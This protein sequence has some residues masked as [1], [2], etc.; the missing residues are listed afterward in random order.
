MLTDDEECRCNSSL[1]ATVTRATVYC[2]RTRAQAAAV[3]YSL[4]QDMCIIDV[5]IP[6]NMF[7]LH[8]TVTNNMCTA[9][10]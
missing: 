3:T 4:F 2:N 5:S 7:S 8:P 10:T 1:D 6:H 9:H